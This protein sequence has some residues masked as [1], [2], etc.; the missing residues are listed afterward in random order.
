MVNAFPDLRVQKVSAFPSSPGRWQE[1]NSFPDYRIQ[2]V[3]SFADF[4]IQYVS[5][6]PGP[7]AAVTEMALREFLEKNQTAGI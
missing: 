6:F 3:D 1:V 4:T 7:T 5:A 2:I